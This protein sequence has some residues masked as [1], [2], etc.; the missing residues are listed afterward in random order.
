ML[1]HL[2]TFAFL[3]LL[4]GSIILTFKT[5]FIQ[6]R[7]IP[8]MIKLLVRSVFRKDRT[9]KHTIPAHRALFA[10]MATAFGIGNIVA[11]IVA[12]G[13]GGHH[14]P[15]A[16]VFLGLSHRSFAGSCFTYRSSRACRFRGRNGRL[17]LSRRGRL[18]G[19]RV[20]FFLIPLPAKHNQQAQGDRGY[21]V[22]KIYIHNQL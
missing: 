5:R 7:S 12:I 15:D 17:L 1:H 3:V 9:S 16:C 6:I 19:L 2:L 22:L 21:H 13:F 10:A 8:L 11:P 14:P 18:I 20:V 4:T